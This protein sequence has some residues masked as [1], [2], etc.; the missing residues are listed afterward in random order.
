[1]ATIAEVIRHSR[2]KK[3]D[4]SWN[5]QTRVTVNRKSAYLETEHL[6]PGRGMFAG[7]L[8]MM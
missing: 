6:A 7:V 1:M 8:R 4:D 3:T 2:K 5:V